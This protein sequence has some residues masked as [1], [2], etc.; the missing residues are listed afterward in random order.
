MPNTGRIWPGKARGGVSLTYDGALPEHLSDVVPVLDAHAL[1]GTFFAYPPNLVQSALEWKRV[2][3][4]GH[5][6]GNHCLMGLADRDGMLPD[7]DPVSALEDVIESER[8]F[9]ELFPGA[10]HSFARPAVRGFGETLDPI[11]PP[12]IRSSILRLNDHVC[13]L[14]IERF[15][16]ARAAQ[17]GLNKPGETSP[18][19]VRSMLADGLD[20][21]SLTLFVEF[22]MAQRS[23]VVFVF[24]GLRDSVFD[25]AAHEGLCRFLAANQE[26][27]MTAPLVE[28]ARL[29]V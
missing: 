27:V 23:W 5:E 11:V 9:E 20:A 3:E 28:I 10:E 12:I 8:L 13:E 25:P 4:S 22:A 21:E 24:G 2:A 16:A 1:R 14:A 18:L 19:A 15:P 17:D 26:S 6:L 29:F 7:V